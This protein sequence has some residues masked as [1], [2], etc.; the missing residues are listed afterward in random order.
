MR[1]AELQDLDFKINA[2]YIPQDFLQKDINTDGRHHLIF[3]TEEM[4]ALLSKSK[5]WYI[6]RT[7]K[8]MKEPFCQ[9]MTI[10]SFV[11]SSD[12]VKQVPLLFVLMSAHW[13]DYIKRC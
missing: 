7:F 12:D 6:D 11:R 8:V 5:T 13:K 3:A 4:V 9:L 1:R 2:E 10:H